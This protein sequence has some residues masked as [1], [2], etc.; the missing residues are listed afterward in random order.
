MVKVIRKNPI[1][2]IYFELDWIEKQWWEESYLDDTP[3]N[4]GYIKKLQEVISGKRCVSDIEDT[5]KRFCISAEYPE[6]VMDLTGRSG[7]SVIINQK[8]YFWLKY[9]PLTLIGVDIPHEFNKLEEAGI[10]DEIINNISINKS[11]I[12]ILKD[13]SIYK[14]I[15]GFSKESCKKIKEKEEKLFALRRLTDTKCKRKT[16]NKHTSRSIITPSLRMEILLRDKM[17]CQFCGEDD[18]LQVHHII[19]VSIIEKLGLHN[20]LNTTKE[21][22]ITIC[23]N[24]NVGLSD[25]LNKET[26]DIYIGEF[27]NKNHPNYDI[28]GMLNKIKELQLK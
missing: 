23:R 15:P 8:T 2:A 10:T 11:C 5:Y 28:C 12:P 20:R 18:Q 6:D 22:L 25:K 9:H 14:E 1:P 19:P 4:W 17:K 24:C 13:Y 3:E 26:I 7:K 27:K 16:R 21:N